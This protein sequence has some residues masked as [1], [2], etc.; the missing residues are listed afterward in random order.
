MNVLGFFSSRQAA[1]CRTATS[2]GRET[3][4]MQP[5]VMCNT[6]S[7]AACIMLCLAL[8]SLSEPALIS[9]YE[10]S[11]LPSLL[12]TSGLVPKSMLLMSVLKFKKRW[13]WDVKCPGMDILILYLSTPF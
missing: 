4:A 1:S 13:I 5:C 2:T 3:M 11:H 6:N 9:L 12:L 7:S 8:G 10:R